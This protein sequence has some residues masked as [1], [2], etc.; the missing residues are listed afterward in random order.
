MI[1]DVNR[2]EKKYLIDP[3]ETQILKQR[4]RTYMKEDAY[5]GVNGYLVRSVYFD[6]LNDN[7]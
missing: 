5:N 2:V 7:D 1:L 3:V 4:L 6:T